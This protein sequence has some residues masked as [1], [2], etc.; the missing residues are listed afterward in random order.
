MT[1]PPSFMAEA[2]DLSFEAMRSG[3]GGPYGAVVVKDG[4]IIGRGMN[5]V[6]SRNDP[7]HHAEMAAIWEA[8]KTLNTWK[9]EGCELYTSC[10][11]CPMCMAAAYWA[12]IDRVYYGNTAETAAAYDFNSKTIYDELAKPR[13]QRQIPME[14]MMQSEALAA[15]EEWA[16]KPDKATY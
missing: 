6:T 15:F 11:P 4:Q 1:I 10:E 12:R 5:E 7:T 2:I 3:K 14:P 13:D 8:C 9:L 16:N